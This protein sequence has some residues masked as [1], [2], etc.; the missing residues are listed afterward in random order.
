MTDNRRQFSRISFKSEGHLVAGGDEF[1]V[2]IFDLSLKGALIRPPSG[3]F[4]KIGTNVV[5][6]MYL[7][8][9]AELFIRMPATVVHHQGEMF[10]LAAREIDLDSVTHL[11]RL[12]ELNLGDQSLLDRDLGHLAHA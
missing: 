8:E 1:K 9:D 5:L 10:G 7:G 3:I 4:I 2:E 12:V 11:R 6:D